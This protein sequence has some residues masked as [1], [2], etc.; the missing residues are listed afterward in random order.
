MRLKFQIIYKILPLVLLFLL[1][2]KLTAQTGPDKSSAIDT[3]N[4]VSYIYQGAIDYNLMIASSKG[5][6]SEINR[7]IS[8]GADVSAETEQ[9]VTPLIFA[10]LNNQNDAVKLLIAYGADI[11][12]ATMKG[13]M[14]L[15]IAVKNNNPGMAE[16]LIRAGADINTGDKNNA[17]PLHF[18]A[19]YGFLQIADLLLYYEASPDLK[20]NDGSTPLLASAWAGYPDLCDLLIQNRASVN[21]KDNEGYTPLMITALTG[22]TVIMDLLLKK[23]A[24]LYQKNDAG[25]NA[26]TL[27]IIANNGDAIKYL[28]KAGN[29]WDDPGFG[30]NNAYSVAAKYGRKKAIALLEENKIAGRVIYKFDQADLSL[31]TRFVTHDIYTGFSLAF[32]EPFLNAGIILG[33]DTRLWYNRLLIK[34]S[35]NIYYQYFNKSSLAY[36]GLFKDFNIHDYGAKGVLSASTSLSAGKVFGSKLKG[37]SNSLA[38][39]FVIIPEAGIKWTVRNIAISGSLSYLKSDFYKVSPLWTRIGITYNLYFDNVRIKPKILKWI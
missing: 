36:A 31:S 15:I 19:V 5:Y 9:G 3:S 34:Q 22:D 2:A 28:L 37:T 32:K 11:E 10:A 29:K 13:E 7:L 25:N 20:A 33:I 39:R 16:D 4:Y 17:T 24:G 27:A 35:E 26:L 1:P 6:L 12:K 38:D 30:A 18:A 23:G 8:K 21:E 14:P